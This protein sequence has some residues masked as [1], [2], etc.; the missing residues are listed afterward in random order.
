[1]SILCHISTSQVD[2]AYSLRGFIFKVGLLVVEDAVLGVPN[3]GQ[4]LRLFLEE[5]SWQGADPPESVLR[6]A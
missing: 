6:Q 5:M 4:Q 3:A 2:F 1:M